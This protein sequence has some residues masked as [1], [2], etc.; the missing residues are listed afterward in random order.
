MNILWR[1]FQTFFV[2]MSLFG[3]PKTEQTN[4]FDIYHGVQIFDSYRW[5]EDEHSAQTKAWIKAENDY[6]QEY[7]KRIPERG[8]IR[9]RLVK[10]SDYV[11]YGVPFKQAGRYFFR[12]KSGAQ[13]QGVV[14]FSN[15]LHGKQRVLLDPNLL[16]AEGT[17]ALDA[18]EVSPDGKWFAY[19][20]SKN[21]SDWQDWRIR[22][23]GTRRDLPDQLSWIK[24]SGVAWAGD[25]KGL[26]YVRYAQTDAKEKLTAANYFSQIFYHRRDTK[27]SA[28]KLIFEPEQKDWSLFPKVTDDGRYLVI[29]ITRGD[30]T[31]NRVYYLD[32]KNPAAKLVKLIDWFEAD[33]TFIASKGSIFWF[34][35]TQDAPRGRLIAV[36]INKPAA[37]AKEV[38]AQA[39]NAID[40]ITL[41]NNQFVV[42]YFQDAAS[43]VKIFSTTGQLVRQL[44][45]PAFSTVVGFTGESSAKET[46]YLTTSFTT[47]PSVYHLDMKNGKSTLFVAPK[48]DYQ[49]SDFETK[50]VFY[51]SKDGTKIPM[52]LSYKRGLELNG[53]NPTLLYGYGGF[54]ISI[55]PSFSP[56]R[57]L[58]MQMGGVYASANLRGGSEYGEQWHQTGTKLKKQNVFDDFIAAAE[59]LIENKYTSPAKLA[60]SGASNGGLL[61]AACE[62]QRPDLFGATLPAVGVMDMLRFQKFTTG[63]AWTNDYGSSDDPEEFKALLAYSPL[64]NLN[65]GVSY[66][67]TLITTGD[68][69]DRVVPA[70]SFKFAARMQ[71]VQ[72]GDKPILIRID[73]NAGHGA[74]KP[75]SKV[76][77]EDTDV[78]AFLLLE[79]NVI[80]RSV[81]TRQFIPD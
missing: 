69:D 9:A 79:L 59:W 57:I 34:K 47:A 62:I 51:S 77:D 22:Q 66:P 75:S 32:L 14:S 43:Q 56:K 24:F 13:N 25:S 19:G 53:Q 68:H 52:F 29:G 71:E 15:A 81:T 76:I 11:R 38:I 10:L 48:V 5:L 23:I 33:Y 54:N 20:L 3:Y 35:T 39:A 67:A 65:E 40:Q 73:T 2:S 4:H 74:G 17:I 16:S 50:Q 60:I 31:K 78:L 64:H 21:G 6:T 42:H 61:V 70:H 18:Y 80:A 8:E 12:Q 27:Q 46:F 37:P 41:V 72:T 58:W 1:C 7:L 49:P 63:W 36:D 30:D 55:P 28:D 44:D 26:F 45:I